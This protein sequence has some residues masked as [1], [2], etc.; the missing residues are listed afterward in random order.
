MFDSIAD[1]NNSKKKK[2]RKGVIIKITK[3]GRERPFENPTVKKNF[4]HK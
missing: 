1:N 2:K 3:K 4:R